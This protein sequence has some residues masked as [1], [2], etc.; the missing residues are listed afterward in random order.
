MP[1]AKSLAKLRG[2]DLEPKSAPGQRTEVCVRLPRSIADAAALAPTP[3]W[4]D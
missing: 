2:G 1:L 4:L 3:G